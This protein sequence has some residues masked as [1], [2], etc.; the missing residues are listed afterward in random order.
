MT[1][2]PVPAFAADLT[3]TPV[4]VFAFNHPRHLSLVLDALAGN[5]LAGRTEVTIFCDG[6]RSVQD[7]E[8][9]AQVREVA[10]AARGF[11]R[12]TVVAR[13]SNLGCARSVITGTAELF[14]V[15][16]R[17]VVIEDDVLPTP[18]AL[19]FLN[20]S[21]IQ[22]AGNPSV[23]SISAWAPSQNLMRLPIDYP[24][25][26]FFFPRFH[27]WGWASWR[28]RW[29]L[30]DWTVPNYDTYRRDA[31]IRA[32]HARG[33]PDLPNMLDAQMAGRI[34]S[35]AIRAEYTRFRFNGLT[36]YPRTSLVS[37]IGLDGSGTH[38]GADDRFAGTKQADR[39]VGRQ[40]FPEAIYVDRRIERQFRR[41][42]SRGRIVAAFRRIWAAP[43]KALS[44]H[45]GSSRKSVSALA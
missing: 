23:F 20:A 15:H 19:R 26:A 32:A 22:Y 17:L 6:E 45:F 40:C 37:N 28:D 34:D 42:Y 3:P 43:L 18:D 13:E 35:W 39:T 10:S 5:D 16:D 29:A 11:G 8:A 27:C 4:A 38:C 9:C 21:L 25:N 31:S 33:G 7:K 44:R 36:L 24:F 12:L 14:R 2:W 1:H 30:N 41:V